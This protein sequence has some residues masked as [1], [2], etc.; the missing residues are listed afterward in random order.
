MFAEFELEINELTAQGV[1]LTADLLC[2]IYAKLN[3]EYFGD[4]I[5]VDDEIALE[6]ARIPHFYYEYY[7]YQYATGFAAAI[8]LSERIL[9][10]GQSA[11][12]A[13]LDFLS[14]GCSKPPIEL[15]QG[16]GVDMT[17]SEPI[18]EALVMFSS[19]VDEMSNLIH[20]MRDARA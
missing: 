4:E 19:L 8:A 13:Y 5:I 16:A 15:L 20:E 11:V 1:G 9:H 10:G 17:T 18:D 3:K 2:E 14:G 6:W 7:V 12:D